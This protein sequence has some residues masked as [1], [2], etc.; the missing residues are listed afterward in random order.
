[1][2]EAREQN[3][4]VDDQIIVLVLHGLDHLLGKHHPE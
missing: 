2:E 4:L 1:V 3:T